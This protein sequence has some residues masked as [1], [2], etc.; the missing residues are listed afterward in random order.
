MISSVYSYYLSQYADRPSTRHDSHKKSELRNV[1]N[2]MVNINRTSPLYKLNLSDEMQRLA[3]DIKESA[4]ELRSFSKELVEAEK[5]ETDVRYKAESENDEIV[6]AKYVG[7]E[8]FPVDGF[9]VEVKQLASN[10]IN[11]GHFLQPKSRELDEGVYSFDVDMSGVTYEL[12]FSVDKHDTAGS[13][14]EKISRLINRSAIGVKAEVVSD[15][16]GNTALSI[17]SE[18]TGVGA[19]R[20]QIFNITDDDS[21]HLKG[22][23]EYLGIDRVV[24]YPGNAIFTVDGEDRTSNNNNFTIN[25]SVEITL[26]GVSENPVKVNV[27]E[28]AEA[29]V[30]DLSQFIN[31]YNKVM[32]FARASSEKFYGGGKLLNEFE[33]ITRAYH[34][35]LSENGF[36]IQEDGRI[37]INEAGKERFSNKNE[38]TKVLSGLDDFRNS[39]V[40]KLDN[41]ISNP[42]EYIDKKIVAYKNPARSFTSPYSSSA[43]AGIMFDGYC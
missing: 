43:Y 13:I 12:Q 36:D 17:V 8:Q 25:K 41:M 30:D 14:Q 5:G 21:M 28:D 19:G 42:M 33:R 11:T 31:G 1:Y 37:A 35:D 27:L 15:S 39:V 10:Q 20:P 38:V 40:R 6:S 4:L 22:T 29:I 34:A 23:V 7:D 32:D 16:L 26:N 9:E 2:K 3:I 18:K 24:Q